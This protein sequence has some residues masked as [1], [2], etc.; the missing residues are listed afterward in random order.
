MAT[1][2][3]KKDNLMNLASM[4][5]TSLAAAMW[6]FVGDSVLALRPQMGERVLEILEKQ[7][8]LEIAGERPEDVLLEIARLLADE[9]GFCGETEVQVEGNCIRLKMRDS[10]DRVFSQQ[11]AQAGVGVNFL[12]AP[13]NT[14]LAALKRMGKNAR[15]DIQDWE[16]GKGAIVTFQIM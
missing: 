12:S 11:L 13:V 15:A 8:G 4:Y 9:F 16:E 14:G 5:I 2:Q 6:D 1:D 3:Q 10:L 7:M